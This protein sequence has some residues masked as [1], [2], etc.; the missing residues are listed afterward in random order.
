M[1]FR[2]AMLLLFSFVGC[3]VFY[4]RR[5]TD[6]AALVRT[7]G[8]RSLVVSAYVAVAYV[9]MQLVTSWFIDA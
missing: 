6:A 8:M 2:A 3:I 9:G 1:I 7:A 4:A 5:D